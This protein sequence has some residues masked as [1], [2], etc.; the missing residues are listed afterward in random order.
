MDIECIQTEEAQIICI[1]AMVCI[2]RNDVLDKRHHLVASEDGDG[3]DTN[4]AIIGA[5]HPGVRVVV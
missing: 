4:V 2:R 3:R 5:P 1:L